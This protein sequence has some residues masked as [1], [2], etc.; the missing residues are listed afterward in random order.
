MQ[1]LAVVVNKVRPEQVNDVREL[2]TTQ[3]AE[4]T[5]LAVI[6]LNTALLSPSMKE[7]NESLCGDLLFGE[8]NL[9]NQVTMWLS[10]Q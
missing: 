2:L 6:P 1:V 3:L 10:A 5:I 7:I 8:A 4:G 9:S